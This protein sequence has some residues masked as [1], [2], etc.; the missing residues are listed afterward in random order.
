MQQQ[1][2]QTL[3]MPNVATLLVLARVLIIPQFTKILSLRLCGNR[4]GQ[5]GIRNYCHHSNH[6]L[7]RQS[8]KKHRLSVCC[9]LPLL[10]HRYFSNSP[11]IKS[12]VASQTTKKMAV[13]YKL[14]NITS[15]TDIQNFEK[16]ESEVEGIE[17][18][19]VLVLRLNNEVHAISPR[20]THYGAPLRIGVIQPDGQ[21]R[22][23]WHGGRTF[24][25]FGGPDERP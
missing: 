25:C 18:A 23:P 5:R 19:K 17:G 9:Q 16:A 21:I 20:C 24:S 22:C 7:V 15:L 11:S 8:S 12:P 10:V 1:F 14:K 2:S 6:S 3:A 4:C 13:E